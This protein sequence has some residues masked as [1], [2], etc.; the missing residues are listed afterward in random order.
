MCF[1]TIDLTLF[2]QGCGAVI[3]TETG[4]VLA[5]PDYPN[6]AHR[7]NCN[8]TVIGSNPSEEYWMEHQLQ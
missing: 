4:G 6:L 8:W 2:L 5:T 3:V 1:T 7:F